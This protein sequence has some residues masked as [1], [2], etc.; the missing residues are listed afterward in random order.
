MQ[1]S[2]I[3]APLPFS[4]TRTCAALPLL[5]SRRRSLTARCSAQ[6]QDKPEQEGQW[7]L[8]PKLAAAA[9]AASLLFSAVAPEDALAA[10]SGGRVGGSSF[11]SSAPRSAPSVPRSS[12]PSVRNYNYYSAPPLVGG[13]GYGGYG[14]GGGLSIFPATPIFF[15]GGGLFNILIF[16]FV[17]ST[18]LG[19]VRNLFNRRRDDEFDD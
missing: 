9:L 18:I 19:V 14:Y 12:G 11:R 17:A 13:Y 16:M 7:S 3:R 8:A 2:L 5:P 4:G 6:K 10:R 15:G 1:T